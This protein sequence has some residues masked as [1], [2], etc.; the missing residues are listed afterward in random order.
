MFA[1]KAPQLHLRVDSSTPRY[2]FSGDSVRGVMLLVLPEPYCL[3]SLTLSLV[4]TRQ[5]PVHHHFHASSSSPPP[6]RHDAVQL[7]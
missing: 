2:L 6:P 3:A 7:L 1:S 4:A 5:L